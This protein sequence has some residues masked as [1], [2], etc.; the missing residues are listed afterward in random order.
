MQVKPTFF[1]QIMKIEEKLQLQSTDSPIVYLHR[2]KIGWKAYNQ[3]AW[4][5]NQRYPT[6]TP[7][8]DTTFDNVS[9]VYISI[10]DEYLKSVLEGK[11]YAHIE[12][13]LIAV[14]CTIPFDEEKYKEWLQQ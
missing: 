13:D 7:L 3:S 9:F 6:Y 14:D 12:N 4:Y 10:P 1:L 5:F 11:S 8:H 2:E